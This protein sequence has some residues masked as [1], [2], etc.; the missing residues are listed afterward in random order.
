MSGLFQF[1]VKTNGEMDEHNIIQHVKNFNIFDCLICVLVCWLCIKVIAVII[2]LDGI[3]R[4]V[5]PD[6]GP[7]AAIMSL[8]ELR[9]LQGNSERSIR[10]HIQFINS[11]LCSRVQIT[12]RPGTLLVTLPRHSF[13]AAGVIHAFA[14]VLSHCA[15]WYHRG[16][17]QTSW[18][19]S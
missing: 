6:W 3:K 7:N 15:C 9:S 13:S 18:M 5:W 8:A 16:V 11:I 4:R 14:G 12:Q 2:S 1:R 17:C 19:K 10:Q